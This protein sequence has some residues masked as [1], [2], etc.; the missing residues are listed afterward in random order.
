MYRTVSNCHI[1]FRYLTA[2]TTVSK[3]SAII[4][5]AF[6]TNTKLY[7]GLT[8][9]QLSSRLST[10]TMVTLSMYHRVCT[11]IVMYLPYVSELC[12][13]QRYKDAEYLTDEGQ[14]FSTFSALN[15]L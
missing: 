14:T 8:Y 1:T 9:R 2:S 7:F 11:G 10:G 3:L 13:D 4:Q 12:P 5:Q 15:L 6:Y